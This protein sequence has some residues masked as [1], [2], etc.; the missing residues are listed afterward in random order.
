[1]ADPGDFLREKLQLAAQQEML[2]G[3]IVSCRR[4][5][6]KPTCACAT[7]DERRHLSNLLSVRLD[8]RTRTLHLRKNDEE[9]VRALVA[10]Y[11]DLISAVGELTRY[12]FSKLARKAGDRRRKADRRSQ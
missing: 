7:N 11:A 5:C 6:G 9:R 10:N 2:R 1:M 8:G 3:S 4:R 12:E